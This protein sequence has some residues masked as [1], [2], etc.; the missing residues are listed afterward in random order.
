MRF[1][2]ILLQSRVTQNSAYVCFLNFKMLSQ[3]PKFNLQNPLLGWLNPIQLWYRTLL[4]GKRID[5]SVKKHSNSNGGNCIFRKS[6]TSEVR[7][8]ITDLR[9]SSLFPYRCRDWKRW[10]PRRSK[11][12]DD[13]SFIYCFWK[14]QFKIL[15]Y[16]TLYSVKMKANIKKNKAYVF[17]L[18]FSASQMYSSIQVW[19]TS[20]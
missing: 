11:A 8:C 4:L 3:Y 1:F 14:T 10:G 12:C 9:K 2:C 6:S 7:V 16:L 15:V 18:F 13:L 17:Y 5:L 20:R 19:T